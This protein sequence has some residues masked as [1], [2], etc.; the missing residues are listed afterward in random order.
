[1]KTYDLQDAAE[2]FD[3]LVEQAAAGEPVIITKAGKA[4]AKLVPIEDAKRSIIGSMRGCLA[5]GADM[6]LEA[7]KVMDPEIEAMFEGREFTLL[8]DRAKNDGH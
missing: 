8:E 2:H 3:E 6:S 1:M 5:P 7:L 4:V